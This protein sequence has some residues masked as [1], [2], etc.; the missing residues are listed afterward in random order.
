MQPDREAGITCLQDSRDFKHYILT[1]TLHKVTQLSQSGSCD[2]D[3]AL[4]DKT[5]LKYCTNIT[6]FVLI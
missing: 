4:T 1:V 5:I 2:G 3:E 6:R